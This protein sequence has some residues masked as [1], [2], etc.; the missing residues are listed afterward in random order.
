MKTL[1]DL[2]QNKLSKKFEALIKL[3]G[4]KLWYKIK[5]KK[6]KKLGEFSAKQIL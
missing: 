5:I 2:M 6:L 4:S 3:S 1:W